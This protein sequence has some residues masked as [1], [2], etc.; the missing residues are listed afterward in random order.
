LNSVEAV[1]RHMPTSKADDT[2]WQGPKDLG[3][4]AVYGAGW[5]AWNSPE[6]VMDS[7]GD[8]PQLERLLSRI[9][10]RQQSSETVRVAQGI[11]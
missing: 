4:V 10:R 5:S 3:V 9:Y 6:Q 11:V 2:L 7:I 8:S 1:F